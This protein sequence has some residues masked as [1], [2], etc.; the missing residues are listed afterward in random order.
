MDCVIPINWTSPFL[1]L[2]VSRVFVHFY[3]IL[4]RNSCF[5]VCDLGLHFLPMSLLGDARQK[6]V[7]EEKLVL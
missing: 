2:G 4:N 6:W 1:V 5:A 7:N 3:F